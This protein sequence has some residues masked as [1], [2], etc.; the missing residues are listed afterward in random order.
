MV[1][2]QNWGCASEEFRSDT[3]FLGAESFIRKIRNTKMQSAYI[4]EIFTSLQGEGIYQGVKQIFIRF[5]GCNLDCDYCDTPESKVKSVKCKVEGE[6]Q[7]I[8]NPVSSKDLIDLLTHNSSFITHNLGYFHSVSVTGG[9]PL[10]QVNFLEEL[11]PQ[12]KKLGLKIY[13]ETNGTLPQE[14]KKIV[15]LIDFIAMDIKL[16]S[17]T[18]KDLFS[19]HY[20]FL[21]VLRSPDGSVGTKDE[22]ISKLANQPT[23]QP[24]KIFVKIVLTKK[25]LDEEIKKSI[26][27]IKTVDPEI[28]LVLQPVTPSNGRLIGD[29]SPH[30]RPA[31][32]AWP[33]RRGVYPPERKRILSWATLA[34][35]SLNDVRV[36]RQKH[37]LWG[38]K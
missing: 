2:R 8:I 12:I 1:Y 32:E 33:K 15:S 13:L 31:D 34:K 25:T 3:P 19:E 11:V 14:L 35:N 29:P 36:I 24:V 37:K 10:L 27:L 26:N 7:E 38:V 5:A 16:P 6:K 9:E 23:S 21:S 22:Q 17:A 20:D 18:G 4:N 30:R 28:P